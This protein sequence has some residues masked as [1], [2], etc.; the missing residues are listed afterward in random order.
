MDSLLGL[1]G[2]TDMGARYVSLVVLEALDLDDTNVALVGGSAD[3]RAGDVALGET[4]GGSGGTE[5]GERGDEGEL[6]G[7]V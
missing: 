7:A 6:H 1:R 2:A 4:G 3:V 5:S